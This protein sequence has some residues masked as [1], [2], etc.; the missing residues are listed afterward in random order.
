M[1]ILHVYRHPPDPVTRELG[2]MLS[3]DREAREF[4]LHQEPVDYDGLLT[5]ILDHDQVI[6]WW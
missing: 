4:P 1:K 3:K 5:L 6:S 2:D